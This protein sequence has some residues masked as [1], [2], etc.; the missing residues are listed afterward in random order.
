MYLIDFLI[1]KEFQILKTVDECN[2]CSSVEP[3]ILIWNFIALK[4]IFD[5]NWDIN[6]HFLVQ[7]SVSFW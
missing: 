1:T 2:F 6:H 5:K 3:S 7:N 4:A